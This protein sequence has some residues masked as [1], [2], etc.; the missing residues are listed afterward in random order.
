MLRRI[1]HFTINHQFCVIYRG[2]I[3]CQLYH[4]SCRVC[5]IMN[6]NEGNSG[7]LFL[8]LHSNGVSD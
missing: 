2:L 5:A 3:F 4:A 1:L 7:I 8:V 6:V